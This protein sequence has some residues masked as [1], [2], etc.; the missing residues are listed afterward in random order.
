[1]TTQLATAKILVDHDVPITKA[2]LAASLL[3]DLQTINVKTAFT[4]GR[5]PSFDRV[6]H[7]L[8]L[9]QADLDAGTFAPADLKRVANHF[10]KHVG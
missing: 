4:A 6:Q 8:D 2:M 3:L 5:G 10:A 9:A 1:M 7:A